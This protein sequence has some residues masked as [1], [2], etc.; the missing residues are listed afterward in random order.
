[1]NDLPPDFD[2]VSVRKKCSAFEVF[3][4]LRQEAKKNVEAFNVG[5]EPTGCDFIATQPEVFSVFRQ[6]FGGHV[7][8]RFVL[9]NDEIQI[10]G[11]GGITVNMTATLTLN[12]KGQ[13]RL[14]VGNDE[15]DRWQVLRRAL[16]PV[17][18]RPKR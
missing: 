5:T 8:V 10:E 15:L 2:W 3:E 13:C 11:A 14:R 16:E 4:Q 6:E 1:M 9:R 17:L 7:G 18:F 12:D